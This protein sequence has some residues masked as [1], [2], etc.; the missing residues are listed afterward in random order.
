M[1]VQYTGPDTGNMEILVKV[2]HAADLNKDTALQPLELPQESE[3]KEG[4]WGQYFFPPLQFL[5]VA[6]LSWVV[7]RCCNVPQHQKKTC[8]M[9]TPHG[10]ITQFPANGRLITPQMS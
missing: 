7:G 9:I 8:E 2:M 6:Q 3:W 4:F 10:V 1:V 5:D